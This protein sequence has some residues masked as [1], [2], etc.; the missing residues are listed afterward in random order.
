MTETPEGRDPTPEMKVKKLK[1]RRTG[2]MFT[3]SEHVQCPYCYGEGQTI[4][5]G[6][7]YKDFCE[8][9]QGEDPINFGFPPDGTRTRSG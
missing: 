5:K 7:D 3:V 4:E 8:F 9:R 1:C 6:G 2:Q